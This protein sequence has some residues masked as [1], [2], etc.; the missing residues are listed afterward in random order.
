MSKEDFDRKMT[1]CL[2]MSGM[3]WPG[4]TIDRLHTAIDAVECAPHGAL[5]I[6]PLLRAAS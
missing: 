6:G 1:G 3:P 2:E 5:V 4:D